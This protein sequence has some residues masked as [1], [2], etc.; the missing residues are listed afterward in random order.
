MLPKSGRDCGMHPVMAIEVGCPLRDSIARSM[1]KPMNYPHNSFA[2][3]VTLL[4]LTSKN[5]EC[6][7]YKKM[8]VINKIITNSN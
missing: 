6:K 8:T 5:V 3:M 1:F 4:A 2:T 7:N